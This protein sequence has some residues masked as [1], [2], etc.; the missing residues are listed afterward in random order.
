MSFLWPVMLWALLI[1][2][3]LV[4]LYLYLLNRKKKIALRYASLTMVKDAMATGVSFRR[5]VPPI[6]FLLGLTVAIVSIA[7]PA[8]VV[9]L[10]SQRGTVILA[11][12]VSG[13][14]RATDVEPN[15]L[16]AAQEAAKAFAK[17][18]PSDTRIGVVAFAGAAMLV[19]SPTFEKDDVIKAIDRFQTQRSTAVGSGILVSLA[20][21]FPEE[22]F[23]LNPQN[24]G[25]QDRRGG[26]RQQQNRGVA[27][28][29]D[30]PGAKEKPEFKPVPPGSNKSAI[31]ILLTDGQTTTGPDPVEAAQKAAEHGIRIF[32]VG[33]GTADGQM[34]GYAG[35]SMRVQLDEDSLK[36]VANATLGSYYRAD[37]AK[38]LKKVYDGLTAQLVVEKEKTE[39]TAFF[40]AAAAILFILSG[41]LSL[42]WF[43]RLI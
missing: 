16:V 33:F 23:D 4:A 3:P 36:K 5:H 21:I 13:S 17:D 28:G 32:T 8:A 40:S 11:M 14:M 1:L 22:Q 19:Q 38:D 27:L 10:P 35:R 9:T 34:L 31:I 37:N 7:R 26:N 15:R 12:D 24:F 29:Q 39:I 25:N 41:A 2:P 6:L 18:Q 43:N 30:D 42:L 20:A